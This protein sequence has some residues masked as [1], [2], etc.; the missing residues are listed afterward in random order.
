ML[1][2]IAPDGSDACD[3]EP[4]HIPGSI[5][6]HGLMLIA[7]T[8]SL[9]CLGEAGDVDKFLGQSVVGQQLS[10]VLSRSAPERMA[11]ISTGAVTVL[12]RLDSRSGPLSAVAYRSGEFAIVEMD[13]AEE[14]PI[15]AVPF[16]VDLDVASTRFERSVSV[17][18]LCRSAATVFRQLTGYDR[19]M[20]YQFLDD[21]ADVVVGESVA[22]GSHSFMN[23]HFPASDI[24][25]Q[26]RHS[27][28]ATKSGSSPMLI[29]SPDRSV[30]T[31][32]CAASI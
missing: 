13:S 1:Q 5:Q 3:V 6:P 23:H 31:R 8:R 19:I 24:P 15:E 16:L 32:I 10:D 28:S 22:T 9:L 27:I 2:Q 17:A 21:D 11:S 26:A 4:I 20:V 29:T 12:G 25:K 7:D 18:E 14:T 30:P